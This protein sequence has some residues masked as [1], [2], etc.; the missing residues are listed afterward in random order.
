MCS[1]ITVDYKFFT[2]NYE[3]TVLQI[4]QEA[5]SNPHGMCMLI[6]NETFIQSMDVETIVELLE[7]VKWDRVWIHF[8]FA[9]GYKL[10]LNYTHGFYTKDR[11]YMVMHNGVI[12]EGNG[13]PVDSMWLC[14]LIDTL[15]VDDAIEHMICKLNFCNTFVVEVGNMDWHMV[16]CSSGTLHTDNNG[17]YSTHAIG[18]IKIPVV[19]N[20][21]KSFIKPKADPRAAL[22]YNYTDYSRFDDEK[23]SSYKDDAM[24]YWNPPSYRVK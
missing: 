5:V 21:F 6:D 4:Y 24:D 18:A 15:G 2:D 17:N 8:R 10:G 9:T 1:I 16:R 11:K 13:L 3:E 7:V 23:W 19:A 12:P 22:K 20:T 14:N